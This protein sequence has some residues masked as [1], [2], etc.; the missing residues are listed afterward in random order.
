MLRFTLLWLLVFF[1]SLS[2][3]SARPAPFAMRISCG[4]RENVQTPPTYAR[5]YK[6]FAYTGGIPANATLPSFITPPLK[7]LRYFPLSE[8]PENCYNIDR[9]PKGH[10]SVRIFF[11]LVAQPE[12]D[13]EPLFDVSVEGTLIHSLNSG[14]TSHDDQVFAEALVFLLDGTVSICFHS[15]GHGDP[16]IISIEILQ[17]DDKAYFFGPEWGKGVILKTTSR[18]TCGTS[19]P[20]FDEDYS[21]DHWGGDR[22][23]NPIRTFGQNADEPR[24]TESSIKQASVA[25][26]FYPEAL[27]QSAIVS[28]DSQP[29]LAYTMDVDPNKNYSLWLHF[30]EIDATITGAGQRVF[31]VLI[32]GDTVFQDIDVVEMSGDRYTALVLNTTV[33]LSG[34]TLTI[35]LRPKNG[36]H[37]ILNA[38]EVFEIIAA[39]FQTLPEEVRALQALKKAL[40]LP[41]RF[42]WNGDPCVPKEHPWSGAD[43]HFDNSGSNWFIDGLGLDN[44][45]LRGFLPNEIS[46][47]HHLQNLNLSGN[48]IHG[49]IPSSLGTVTSLEIL[50]LSYNFLNGSIP[51]SLGQLT[52]LRRLN[53]N[54]NSLSG[55]VPAALG[56]RL[57]NGA[58]FNVLVEK[59]AE[60]TSIKAD[61]SSKRCSLCK[62]KDPLVA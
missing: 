28:T 41:N 15:T 51:E 45:G 33:A 21:G 11:G 43:C 1:L 54:S 39:E 59:A 53:L 36:N 35:T 22:F 5:W 55:R 57:L 32:N 8:G 49:T 12:F 31:D 62:G 18:L 48:S 13:N 58:S 4:A 47:L 7:S 19:K 17:V 10:Y 24:S 56:G 61:C 50:D 34:R 16:A 2:S 42:G 37:A 9:V 26:N 52:A 23:W 25:P 6:D 30:A 27:Y 29:D 40:G 46:Q 38:I 20:K 44:Q 60:Y 3:S 14:W